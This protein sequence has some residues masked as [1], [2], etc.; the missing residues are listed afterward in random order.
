MN[1]SQRNLE[2]EYQ[3]KDSSYFEVARDEM[4]K[5]VPKESNTVLDVGCG[6]GNFGYLIKKERNSKVW[7]VELDKASAL[8]AEQK[9]DKVFCS[10]FDSNLDLTKK[11]FDCIVLNDVLEHFTDP[12]SALLYCKE[13]L[14]D[15]G[16]IIASI[17]NVRY[18]DNMWNLLVRKDWEYT[19]WGILDK[20]H[21]RFFTKK[22]IIST[23]EN[24]GYQINLIEG[25]N[26]IEN[27]TPA[28][29]RKFKLLNKLLLNQI[30]D[31]RYLQFAV[32]AS[33]KWPKRYKPDFQQ[34]IFQGSKN[35]HI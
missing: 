22:S 10:A 33:Q 3:K 4:L 20:T 24:L 17:P 21:L 29:T 18:F 35:E 26:P 16:V 27:C 7:G 1:I 31:M 12:D 14:R 8:V 15:E 2:H 30:E 5:Y 34:H 13:L 32:V 9:L 11:S 6:R 23:F 25:I 19:T 28:H